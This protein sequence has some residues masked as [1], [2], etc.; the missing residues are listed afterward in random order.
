M[1]TVL[2]LT[3][4]GLDRPG[5]VG[6]LADVIAGLEANW[7]Q[8]R[9]LHL[10]DRFIGLLEVHV[11]EDRADVLIERLQSLGDLE[12]HITSASP[13]PPPQPTVE[14]E[15]MGMDH[16]GIVSEVFGVLGKSQVNVETLRTVVEPAANSGHAL[17]KA[18]AR[19]SI[20]AAIGLQDLQRSL[21]NIAQD[22]MVTIHP[23]GR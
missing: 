9:M 4:S 19:L 2:L 12:I 1:N 23:M 18:R 17:F 5:L 10:A 6:E 8:S 3:L 22:V 13:S 11:R 14:L 7:E 15:I 16:P 20:P 21:E